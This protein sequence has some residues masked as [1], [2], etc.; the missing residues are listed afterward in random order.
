[1][2]LAAA[3]NGRLPCTGCWQQKGIGSGFP[4][5]D[6]ARNDMYEIFHLS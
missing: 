4:V 2:L 3:T 6:S 1:M 5:F